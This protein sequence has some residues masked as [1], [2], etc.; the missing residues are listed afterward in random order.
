[1]VCVCVCV[2]VRERETERERLFGDRSIL[3]CLRTCCHGEIQTD[4]LKTIEEMGRKAG[5]ML[6]AS[7]DSSTDD[8][9][10]LLED[11]QA[12]GVRAV[13]K[14]EAGNPITPEVFLQH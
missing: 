11:V 2:D 12:L 7:N 4:L 9:I 10:L 8:E 13:S 5:C 3:L 14:E 6:N 1:S